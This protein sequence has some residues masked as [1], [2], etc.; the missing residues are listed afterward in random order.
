M[1][2]TFKPH[3]NLP[4]KINTVKVLKSAKMKGQIST[5]LIFSIFFAAIFLHLSAAAVFAA[6]VIDAGHGGKDP[7]ATG[8][9]VQEKDINL[10]IARYTFNYLS[11]NGYR[12][13]M[14]RDKDVYISLADRVNFSNSIPA[15][16]FVSIHQNSFTSSDVKGIE[17]Y[18][19]IGS[20]SGKQLATR[21][22]DR[23]KSATGAASR[24]V[25]E[26]D[27]YVLRNTTAIACLVECG[28]LTNAQDRTNL[29]NPEYQRK[30]GEAIAKGIIDFITYDF[31]PLRQSQVPS[32]SDYIPPALPQALTTETKDSSTAQESVESSQ[33][34]CSSFSL[35]LPVPVDYGGAQLGVFNL[36]LC[37]KFDFKNIYKTSP[38]VF[39][40]SRSKVVYSNNDS[41]N[42]IDMI[43]LYDYR[44][45]S[46]GVHLFNSTRNY[47]FRR[48]Y[49]SPERY[50]YLQRML[51]CPAKLDSDEK[52]DV[53]SLYNYGYGKYGVFFLKSSSG[54]VPRRRYISSA[55][56][57][58]VE[59]SKAISAS[60]DGDKLTDL[61]VLEDRGKYSV[62]VN[63]LK[64]TKGYA[65]ERVYT[66]ALWTFNLSNATPVP[67]DVD[68]DGKTD[69]VTFYDYRNG[70]F[71]LFA[72]KS[73]G[74]FIPRRISNVICTGTQSP[75]RFLASHL[76]GDGKTDFA[77][78]ILQSGKF[79]VF[80][81]LSTESYKGS[82]LK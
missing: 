15:D 13:Y 67:A 56:S 5:K 33:T 46:L 30:M 31:F 32:F 63:L 9:G 61:I 3:K 59:K 79:R 7:G 45:G 4:I 81:F 43:S 65:R 78:V 80:R 20:I 17:V 42:S 62:A 21:I 37:E 19:Y 66:S 8:N 27:Y 49:R 68:A 11:K 23:I 73:S 1:K 29:T 70:N 14:T 64:S 47:Y 10:E 71:A 25:K 52:T 6:L 60:L 77:L 39:S 57:I 40:L 44:N 50:F 28:F 55:G 24:G 54:Y 18:H 41:D 22:H 48:V 69:A 26:A 82:E 36:I 53:I 51:P 16:I 58:Y 72:F 2:F 75:Y 35:S 38:N 76:D 74:G 34:T 12:V